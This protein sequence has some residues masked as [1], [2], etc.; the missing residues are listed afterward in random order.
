MPAQRK[1]AVWAVRFCIEYFDEQLRAGT[2]SGP[3]RARPVAPEQLET[4][5]RLMDR[6]AETTRQ[7]EG[8]LQ[9]ALCLQALFH[10]LGRLARSP[11]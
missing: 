9:V 2:E 7:I 3:Y 11:V 10:D 1:A 5:G 4:L 6:A 8:N